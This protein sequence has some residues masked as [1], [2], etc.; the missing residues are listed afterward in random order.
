MNG[1]EIKHRVHRGLNHQKSI[2]LR[3]LGKAIYG[4]SNWSEASADYQEEHNLLTQDSFINQWLIDQ[5]ERKW[6][7]TTGVVEYGPFAPLPPD[8]PKSPSP[9]P[10]ATGIATTGVVLTWNAGPWA[11]K[12]DVYFGTDP[13]TMPMVASNLALGP[14]PSEWD[15]KTFSVSGPLQPGTV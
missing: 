3:G 2:L 10:Q 14:S 4:S 12:Y 7:N 11:H 9:V 6:N 15:L 8:Q 1:I 5:F 13:Y